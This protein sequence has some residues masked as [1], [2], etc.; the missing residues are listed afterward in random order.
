MSIVET[1]GRRRGYEFSPEE[2]EHALT[3]LALVGGNKNRA[4][5]LLKHD[6]TF[7]R[8]PDAATLTRWKH[9]HAERYATIQTE[10][11]PKIEQGTIATLKAIAQLSAEGQMAATEQTIK[12]I[13]DL[14]GKDAATVAR[15]L[16]I[17]GGVAVDKHLLLEGRPN[18]IQARPDVERDLES[19]ARRMGVVFESTA[20]DITDAV[21]VDAQTRAQRPDA[22]LQTRELRAGEAT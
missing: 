16:A 21:Q 22:P 9:E 19:L 4:R 14:D 5:E 17:A 20:D 13:P 2:I 15:N 7:Q 12:R 6:T 1:S 18:V 11:A 8:T 3:A 10:Q